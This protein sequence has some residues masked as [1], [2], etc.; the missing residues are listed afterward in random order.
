MN[1][2]KFLQ[3]IADQGQPFDIVV[4][5]PLLENG[6]ELRMRFVVDAV[7]QHVTKLALGY[8]FAEAL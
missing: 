1:R 3:R 7:Y 4:I 8:I 5:G 6:Q 2:E